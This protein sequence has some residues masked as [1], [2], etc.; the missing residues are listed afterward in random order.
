M[1]TSPF[2]RRQF[3]SM[4]GTGLAVSGLLFQ[5][6]QADPP[7]SSGGAGLANID[8]QSH[9]YCPEH[10]AL[11]EKRTTDPLVYHKDGV[12]IVKMGDWDRKVLPNHSD[13]AA[14]LPDLRDADADATMN[15]WQKTGG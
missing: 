6:T 3:V 2:T 9:L 15:I 14:K 1:Q 11:M 7:A 12:R 4:S 13:A 5:R 10:L 8:C